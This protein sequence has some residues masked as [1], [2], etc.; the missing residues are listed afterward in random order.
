MSDVSLKEYFDRR[1]D[2]LDKRVDR[3]ILDLETRYGQHFDLND[4]AINKAER[5]VNARLESMNEIREAMKDQSSKMATR[6]ELDLVSIQV[7]ELRRDKANLD[8]RLAMLS[9]GVS[10]IVSILTVVVSHFLG[11]G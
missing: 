9:I 8:G 2:D 3:R 4:T 7:Q 1:V 11:K 6:V 10:I 5:A